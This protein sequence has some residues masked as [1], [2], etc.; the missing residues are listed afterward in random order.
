MRPHQSTS[1]AEA[2][3]ALRKAAPNPIHRL[4]TYWRH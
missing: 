2:R 1:D 3:F 4:Y